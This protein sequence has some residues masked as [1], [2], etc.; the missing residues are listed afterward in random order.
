LDWRALRAREAD[1]CGDDRK[2]GKGKGFN[3]MCAM[4][5]RYVR[6]VRQK[7]MPAGMTERKA[8]AKAK[9]KAKPT[10]TAKEEL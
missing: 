9:A 5:R 3:A 4:E 6:D 2:K 7:Q 8:T 10:A 1:P